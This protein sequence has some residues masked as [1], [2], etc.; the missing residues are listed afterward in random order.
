MT[1]LDTTTRGAPR[2]LRARAGRVLR[3][4]TGFAAITLALELIA[5]AGFVNEHLFPPASTVLPR[6]AQLL[7]DLE[8]LGQVG[9]TLGATLAGVGIAFVIA[10]PAGVLIG[11][12]R[13]V[14]VGA[15]PILDFFRSIP[16]IAIIPL[17]VLTLGQGASM[18]IAIVLF[19]CIWP[20]LFNTVYGVRGVD[21]VALETARSFR[22]GTFETWYRV[23]L[24]SALPLI[25]TGVRLALSTGLTV[26]IAAEITVGSQDGI[27]YVILLA[28]YSG[29]NHDTV[30][31]TVVLAGLLGFALNVATVALTGRAVAW[32][33]RGS[34]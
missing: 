14:S 25:L 24:P 2:R 3:G 22:T 5:R 16:G 11:S 28:S 13:A 15:T 20:M 4:L 6:A 17:L 10:V 21:R 12:Y 9:A 7:V 29:L 1:V 27:G 30:F 23:V 18:K 19:V 34:N 32:E 31:A 8:F 26:A 33:T